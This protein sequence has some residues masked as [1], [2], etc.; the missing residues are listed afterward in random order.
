[1]IPIPSLLAAYTVT[2]TGWAVLAAF[3]FIALFGQ[4]I[5]DRIRG[6]Q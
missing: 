1:M 6:N 3:A 2:A 4:P 5:S